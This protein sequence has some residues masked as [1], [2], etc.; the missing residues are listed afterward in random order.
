MFPGGTA[1]LCPETSA[2]ARRW[3][4]FGV[5]SISCGR[6]SNSQHQPPGCMRLL[7]RPLVAPQLERSE[8]TNH[9]VVSV[10]VSERE[11]LCSSIRIRV[12][13]LFEPGDER[14]CSFQRQIEIVDAEEQEE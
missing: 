14:A 5:C 10:P 1:T 7:G 4:G 11:L 2:R 8:R 6:L 12:R 3:A 13:L 9:D